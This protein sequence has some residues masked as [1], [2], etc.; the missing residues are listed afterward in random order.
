MYVI[1]NT[2]QHIDQS[3]H[4]RR[5]TIKEHSSFIPY[6]FMFEHKRKKCHTYCR[7]KKGTLLTALRQVSSTHASI[8]PIFYFDSLLTASNARRDGA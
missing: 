6:T 3:A 1:L 5:A 8:F 4:I 2:D 7:D